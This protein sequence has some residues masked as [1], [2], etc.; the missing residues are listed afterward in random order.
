M[1]E[2]NKERILFYGVQPLTSGGPGAALQSANPQ[3]LVLGP[4][5]TLTADKKYATPL[6][7][8]CLQQIITVNSY[9]SQL[10]MFLSAVASLEV[11][12]NPGIWWKGTT[13][14]WLE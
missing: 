7:C 8:S 2:C 13:E 11:W 14:L 1:D 9:F 6:A 12:S 3:L 4:L 5:E 10:I